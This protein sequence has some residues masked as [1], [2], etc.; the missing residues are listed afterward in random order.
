[1]PI[2]WTVGFAP[3]LPGFVA[4]VSTSATVSAGATELYYM[5]YLYGFCASGVVFILLHRIF[6]VASLDMFVKNGMSPMATRMLYR[7]KWDDIHY[8]DDIIEG[9]DKQIV[10]KIKTVGMKGNK[11]EVQC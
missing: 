7:E 8:E 1:M 9:T 11:V 2:Q 10:T 6:P 4:A 3:L 5:S